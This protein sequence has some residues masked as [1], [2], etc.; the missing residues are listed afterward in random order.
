VHGV[1][2][3]VVQIGE[4]LDVAGEGRLTATADSAAIQRELE[5][6]QQRLKAIVLTKGGK[7]NVFFLKI[8]NS[9]H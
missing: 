6:L 5:E 3:V 9:Y 1:C 7:S 2:F 8:G 4:F